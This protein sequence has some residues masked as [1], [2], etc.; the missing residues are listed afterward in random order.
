M[1][2]WRTRT[3]IARAVL[4]VSLIF[5]AGCAT[6]MVVTPFTD[7]EP[8]APQSVTVNSGSDTRPTRVSMNARGRALGLDIS[9]QG[10]NQ[11]ISINE[12]TLTY[13]PGRMR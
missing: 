11:D 5:L 12:I 10:S 7:D 4:R 6:T 2:S 1:L 9:S 8:G 3:G 13:V